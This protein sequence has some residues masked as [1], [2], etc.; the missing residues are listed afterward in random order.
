MS[1]CRFNN[2]RP[3]APN[4]VIRRSRSAAGSWSTQRATG[5][6]PATAV[7]V[8]PPDATL[9]WPQPDAVSVR[10][11]SVAWC[12]PIKQRTGWSEIHCA[13]SVRCCYRNPANRSGYV[14]META[15]DDNT[16]RLVRRKI[17]SIVTRQFTL[18]SRKL[19]LVCVCICSE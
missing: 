3:F 15:S 19:V 9:T 4:S 12:L 13:T 5:F 8:R 14:A 1:L 6:S 11:R 17:A 10:A 18:T 7:D 16:A 2:R